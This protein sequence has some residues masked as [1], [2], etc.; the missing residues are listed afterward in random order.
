MKKSWFVVLVVFIT[1]LLLG[2]GLYFFFPSFTKIGDNLRPGGG[3]LFGNT[4]DNSRNNTQST[5]TVPTTPI[6]PEIPVEET[7]LKPE[8][9]F[10]AFKIGE[11]VVS[12]LQPLD[13]R[14]STTSTTTLLLSVG[15]GSGVVRL[16]D[17]ET[18]AMSI[19]GTISIPNI[20]VSE[21]TANSL[22]VVVQSQDVDTLKTIVLK[23]DPRTPTEERFFSPVF[24]SSD[25]TS[26]FIEGNTIYLIEKIKS[27]SEL[28]EYVPST[29]KRTL[30]YRGVFSDLYGFARE[31]TVFLG[32]KAAAGM[33]GFIFKL[34]KAKGLLTKVDS[35]TAILGIPNQGG[36]FV[37]TTEFFSTSAQTR[38]YNTTTK[39]SPLLSIRTMKDK[40]TPDF[41][42][43]TF[44][45]CG[46]SS[47][48]PANMPD[49][50]YM[51]KTSMRDTLYLLDSARISF[52]VL[53]TTD[54]DVDVIYPK[55]SSYSGILT[56]INK[57]D[58]H[59]WIIISK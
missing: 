28:Y 55:S 49:S 41:S 4:D 7:P 42:T 51:G 10:K 21:F 11:Y 16:Y 36:D 20:I 22:Y 59:P 57:K 6:T 40:C 2:V 9:G 27:G 8:V 17:P 53:T 39:E 23:S 35:G 43:R 58:S 37:L 50:W 19:V 44:M 31:G 18:E 13:F 54:E 29:N 3:S 5:T 47:S 46:G 52:S 56:F 14:V 26:F 48:V 45:F 33:Q 30:L 12:S 38:L 25:V 1:L 32:T 34:D 15:R 24:S